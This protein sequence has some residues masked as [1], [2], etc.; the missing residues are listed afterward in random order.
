MRSEV[1]AFAV[2]RGSRVLDF[3]S[4]PG[5][6][7]RV[8]AKAGGKPVLLDASAAMLRAAPFADK[9]QAIF[10]DLPF[11]DA[12]FDAVV[13]GFAIRDAI[14]LPSTLSQ[15]RRVL[16]KGGRFA[17]CDLGKPASL[18]KALLVAA[19]MRTVPIIVGL[20]TAGRVG[21]KYESLYD[22][23]LLVL[24]NLELAH[25]LSTVFVEVTFHETHMGGS[26][27]AMCTR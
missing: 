23:Y 25:A 17:F 1:A 19:Y 3:G 24:N 11:R 15:A 12:V 6:L 2:R 21:L 10:E 22:T 27:V 7:S 5:T 16:K 8:V 9:V 20:A 14:D 4:G 26:I 13:S 18:V